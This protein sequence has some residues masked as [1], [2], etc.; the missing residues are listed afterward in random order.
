MTPAVAGALL[1]HAGQLG[2][3]VRPTTKRRRLGSAVANTFLLGVL[4]DRS[5]TAKWAW[6]AAEHIESVLGD[7]DDVS[8]LWR[9]L[10]RLEGRR[11]TGFL[12]Y[13]YGGR[14]YHR[15]YKTY[16]RQ[17]P[18]AAEHVLTHYEGDPRRIW[19][20]T[21]DVVAVRQRF[22]AIPGVGMALARMAVLMLAR[23]FGVLGGRRALAQL[24]VKPDIH[25][26]RVFRRSGLVPPRG[27]RLDAIAAAQQ[28]HPTFP[29]ALDAPAF[30]IGRTWCRPTRPNCAA[31]PIAGACRRVGLG[32]SR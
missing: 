6:E 9:R 17:L 19:N 3:Y 25:V 1:A 5:V 21:H 29:G 7:A 23:D 18:L 11:L 4:F 20:R 15:H 14:A 8:T 12:R 27:T 31:C 30:H 28:A 26:M 13:G 2:D 22:D 16:A 24:D 10:V 32:R